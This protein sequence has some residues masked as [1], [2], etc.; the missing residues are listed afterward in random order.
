MNGLTKRQKDILTI[1]EDGKEYT[2]EAI[3]GAIG[4]KGPR[5]R[6][7]LNQLVELGKIESIGTTNHHFS[8]VEICDEN[9]LR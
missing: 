9:N 3:A 2:T 1:M 6:Q 8:N 5:T 4:L 7:I